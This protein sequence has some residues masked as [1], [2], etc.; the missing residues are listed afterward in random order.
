MRRTVLKISFRCKNKIKGKKLVF[1]SERN[2][3]WDKKSKIR[4]KQLQLVKQ[5]S[6]GGIRV[7][8]K[9]PENILFQFDKLKKQARL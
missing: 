9:K 4:K 8:T 5:A 2:Y 7:K 3:F 6:H 1:N